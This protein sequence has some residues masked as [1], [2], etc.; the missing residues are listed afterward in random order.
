MFQTYWKYV[1]TAA[2][3][4]VIG[5]SSTLVTQKL[6]VAVKAKKAADSEN[7]TKEED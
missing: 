6:V 2:I 5:V 1:A 7:A 3:S 4:Y